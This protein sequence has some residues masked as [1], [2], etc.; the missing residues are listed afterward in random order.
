MEKAKKEIICS[1][2]SHTADMDEYDVDF[3]ASY[4]SNKPP[5][6]CSLCGK[7]GTDYL[8]VEQEGMGEGEAENW[9]EE[10]YKRFES[11]INGLG[12]VWEIHK[13]KSFI[14]Q[15][16]SQQK[17]EI[18][19]KIEN[20]IKNM[21]LCYNDGITDPEDE[22]SFIEGEAHFKEHCLKVLDQHKQKSNNKKVV[23]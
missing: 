13:I 17:Q 8:V 19:Y 6:K 14:S 23:K 5:K 9:E 7:K 22:G 3:R 12:S 21:A 11:E 16:L 1:E 20:E 18:I 10:F 4:K 15:L 2:C